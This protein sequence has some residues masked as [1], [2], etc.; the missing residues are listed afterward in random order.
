MHC[1]MRKKRPICDSDFSA[2]VV[3]SMHGS[4]YLDYTVETHAS[5]S[6]KV[7]EEFRQQELLCDLVLH[8]TYKDKT[9]DF[10]V[11]RPS[12]TPWMRADMGRRDRTSS[13]CV[14]TQVHKVV[15]ASCSPYFRAMFTSSFRECSAPEVTLCD[16]CPQVLG[17]LIDFAYTSH[18]TVGEKCVLHL[19]LAAMR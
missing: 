16:V 4:G 2:I 19:L 17:R 9:V 8:A 15:L 1:P 5:R 6:M 18:I 10:K 11:R 7:M 14:S 12:V 13:A 3:P